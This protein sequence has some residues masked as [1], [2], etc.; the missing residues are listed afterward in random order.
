MLVFAILCLF[1]EHVF[2]FDIQSIYDAHK[3]DNCFKDLELILDENTKDNYMF[4]LFGPVLNTFRAPMDDLAH[5]LTGDG[6]SASIIE[7]PI[8]KSV[9]FKLSK[10]KVVDELNGDN[11]EDVVNRFIETGEIYIYRGKLHLTDTET[12]VSSLIVLEITKLN[13]EKELTTIE[14]IRKFL[15]LE[16]NNN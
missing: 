13:K 11:I 15:G 12:C 14:Y 2:L 3:Y 7:V 16:V 4:M 8:T 9:L 5:V 1:C 6:Y 10:Y